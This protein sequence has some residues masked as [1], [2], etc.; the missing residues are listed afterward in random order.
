MSIAYP[1]TRY[2]IARNELMEIKKSTLLSFYDV[3][4]T[5]GLKKNADYWF[6]ASSN[7]IYF[8]NGSE[9]HLIAV[10]YQQSDPQFQFLGSTEYTAGFIEEAATVHPTAHT[11]LYT[12]IRY[13][14][15]EFGMMPKMLITANPNKGY[16]YTMFYKPHTEG[17]LSKTKMYIPSTVFDNPFLSQHYIDSFDELP[18]HEKERLK[19]GSWETEQSDDAIIQDYDKI[20]DMFTNELEEDH[21]NRYYIICDVAHTGKDKTVV[22]VWKGMTCVEYKSFAKTKTTEV[23][24]LLQT[25]MR[26]YSVPASR[27]WVDATG[28]GQA[29]PDLVPGI[30]KFFTNSA[31]KK[32]RESLLDPKRFDN[33]KTQCAYKLADYIDQRKICIANISDAEK[34]DL[35]EDLEQIRKK[36]A[37]SEGKL[38]LKPKKEIK[39]YLGRS[40]DGGDVLI[41]RMAAT[42]TPSVGITWIGDDDDDD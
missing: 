27:V 18:P 23:A 42:L 4:K 25:R 36:D 21:D 17:V 7:I 38:G 15:E 12:R 3:A 29:I 41:I 40:P 1:G 34:K 2:F 11:I 33:I 16:T 20:L 14:L 28:I 22:T 31:P 5:Y 32:D 39:K 24:V 8:K 37:E 30:K 35:I 9:I 26:K 10:A 13:R 6:N 19:N